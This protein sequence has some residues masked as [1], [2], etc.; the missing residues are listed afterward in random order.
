MVFVARLR[1]LWRYRVV[2]AYM[3]VRLCPRQSGP[4]V[5]LGTDYGGWWVPVACLLPG[6]VAFCAGAGE[7]ISFDLELH[8]R[9]LN[10]TTFDPTPRAVKFV[11]AN[12]PLGEER[13]RLEPIGWWDEKTMLRFYAP[14][15]PAHVSHSVVNLQKTSTF[16]EAEVE[17]VLDSAAR[18][19][20]S[21]PDIIKMDIEGAE[22]NVIGSLLDVGPLPEVLCVEF[23]QP[24]PTSKTVRAVQ[25]LR[26]AGLR[27]EK[28]DKWN[29]TFARL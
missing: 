9:G 8:R 5:R 29:Y 27:L 22:Y 18:L 13:F 10:V 3:K 28:I 1:S 19:G 25:S 14:S 23:D 4:M 7:D 6:A 15:N 2:P 12:A 21:H 11:M 16:F 20:V 17:R 24:Q 26:S